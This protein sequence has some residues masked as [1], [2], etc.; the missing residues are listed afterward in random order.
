MFDDTVSSTV[1]PLLGPPLGWMVIPSCTEHTMIHIIY[2]TMG[3]R[4]LKSNFILSKDKINSD[5]LRKLC[6]NCLGDHPV[7]QGGYPQYC[8]TVSWVHVSLLGALWALSTSLS[9]SV[10]CCTWPVKIYKNMG[11]NGFGVM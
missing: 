2:Y 5:R 8:C 7:G 10:A 11:Y 9:L 4:P 6:A 1:R 3:H